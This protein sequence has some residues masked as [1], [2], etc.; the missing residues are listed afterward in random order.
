M[1]EIPRNPQLDL[2]FACDTR[3]VRKICLHTCFMTLLCTFLLHPPPRHN[4]KLPVKL[5]TIRNKSETSFNLSIR[6]VNLL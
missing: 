6:I 3:E 2:G 1:D 5:D 4:R